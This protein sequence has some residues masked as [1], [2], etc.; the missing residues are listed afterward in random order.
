MEIKQYSQHEEDTY[1]YNII[2]DNNIECSDFFIDIGACDGIHLSNSR[3]Y[4]ELYWNGLLIEPSH[5]Y[6][7]QLFSN[8]KHRNDV[9]TIQAAITDYDGNADFFFLKNHPDHSGL[10]KNKGEKYMVKAMTYTTMLKDTNNNNRDIGIINIDAEGQDTVILSQVLN[11]DHLPVFIIIES[12]N[13]LERSKQIEL[14]NEKYHL[15]NVLSVNTIWI[16]KERWEK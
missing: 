16:L 3:L 7:N 8:Y 10:G 11:H 4:M 2:K 5:Y 6:Y 1:I 14:L 9:Q 15:L 12:N 13:M